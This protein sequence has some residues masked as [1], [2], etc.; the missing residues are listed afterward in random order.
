M[1]RVTDLRW[2]LICPFSSL[3]VTVVA[4]GEVDMAKMRS[5]SSGT[6]AVVLSLLAA[7][8]SSAVT[9]TTV[10]YNGINLSDIGTFLSACRANRQGRGVKLRYLMLNSN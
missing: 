10:N 3:R 6:A 5:S 4:T 2:N 1:S 9:A 8:V 7:A